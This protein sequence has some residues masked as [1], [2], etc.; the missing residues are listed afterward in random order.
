MQEIRIHFLGQEDPLEGMA[1]HSSILDWKIPWTEQPGRSQSTALQELTWLSDKTTTILFSNNL[2]SL[3]DFFSFKYYDY[4]CLWE[5]SL[6]MC[7][8]M[9]NFLWTSGLYVIFSRQEYWS[10]CHFLFR[11][12]FRPRDWTCISCVGRWIL[13]HGAA[14]EAPWP[15]NI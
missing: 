14:W 8:V 2:L 15:T 1:T 13:Y 10:G 6:L 4:I 5:L 9:S 12:S 3:W 7:S 11:E